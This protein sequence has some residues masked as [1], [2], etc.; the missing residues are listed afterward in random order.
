MSHYSPLI[1]QKSPISE[2]SNKS[3]GSSSSASSTSTSSSQFG[4]NGSV[5]DFIIDIAKKMDLVKRR[6]DSDSEGS[7]KDLHSSTKNLLSQDT[8]NLNFKNFED[9]WLKNTMPD[10]NIMFTQE[11]SD[12]ILRL[13][14][15][16]VNFVDTGTKINKRLRKELDVSFMC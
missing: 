7:E 9:Y 1:A 5:Y 8:P 15:A 13:Q 3:P 11:H 10:E 12:R 6:E 4:D 14:R 2:V 16:Y